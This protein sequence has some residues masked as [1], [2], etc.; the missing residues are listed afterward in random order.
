MRIRNLRFAPVAIAIAAAAAPAPAGPPPAGAP[1]ADASVRIVS[2]APRAPITG[3][4][5]LSAQASLRRI[6][7]VTLLVDGQELARIDDPFKT[8][9][10]IGGATLCLDTAQIPNGDHRVEFGFQGDGGRTGRAEIRLSTD[11]PAFRLIGVFPDRA[12]YRGGETIEMTLDTTHSGLDVSVDFSKIDSG[13]VAGR[14]TVVPLS[15]GQYRVRYTLSRANTRP[16]GLYPISIRLGRAAAGSRLYVGGLTFGYLPMRDSPLSLAEDGRETR[17]FAPMP[18]ATGSP[19]E[20]LSLE[21]SAVG[22]VRIGDTVRITGV[23]AAARG[24]EA[25]APAAGRALTVFFSEM[26]SDGFDRAPVALTPCPAGIPGCV[27]RFAVDLELTPAGAASLPGLETLNLR[28]GLEDARGRICSPASL[29]VPAEPVIGAPPPPPGPFHVAGKFLYRAPNPVFHQ[30][31]PNDIDM[32]SEFIV[33]HPVRFATVRVIRNSDGVS[34]ASTRLN[35]YGDFAMDFSSPLGGLVHVEAY[36]DVDTAGRK[37]RVYDSHTQVY[38]LSSSS[39]VPQ[40][41]PDKYLSTAS[42]QAQWLIFDNMAR[43]IDFVAD[44]AGRSLPRINVLWEHGYAQGLPNGNYVGGRSCTLTSYYNPTEAT[45]GQL[46]LTSKLPNFYP[47][48]ND[49]EDDDTGMHTCVPKPGQF[50]GGDLDDYDS[51]VQVHEFGH[52][53][54]HHINRAESCKHGVQEPRSAWCEG[55]PTAMGQTILGS[56]FYYDR[57]YN[58]SGVEV[59]SFESVDQNTGGSNNQA[60]MPVCG[61]YSDGWV[62]RLLYDFFDPK[63]SSLD[64]ITWIWAP[65]TNVA[66]EPVT[67]SKEGVHFGADFDRIG[68]IKAVMGV[69]SQ[70]MSVDDPTPPDRGPAGPEFVDFLDGWLA[71]GN[72]QALDI[73]TLAYSVMTLG[74]DFGFLDGN[75]CHQSLGDAI[76]SFVASGDISNR[77][78]ANSLGQ[79]A[80][81]AQAAWESGNLTLASNLLD[82]FRHEVAAQRGKHV[83]DRAAAVLDSLALGIQEEIALLDP[84]R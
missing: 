22:P 47:A 64:Q 37:I 63:S 70:Y 73:L 61:P 65:A 42:Y 84:G 25:E 4:T 23:V 35:K 2:Q 1:S 53:V 57:V 76:D 81:H 66:P 78:V 54:Q 17:I 24:R 52:F 3:Y 19:L 6:D 26:N 82:A 38:T 68:N 39:W 79:K 80:A 34:L 44:F 56:P 69:L 33:E 60:V 16:V 77:G 62:W 14:E 20:I 75:L 9:R 7:E 51:P 48:T 49:V 29:P 55:E 40:F 21:S 32:L 50:L 36:T 45:V 31:G 12:V 72:G 67:V 13:Y 15:D 58:G 43:G 71:Q 8:N 59:L 18:R 28:F 83:S 10:L 41:E 27:G 74:Y 30:N 46:H 5:C 11:N